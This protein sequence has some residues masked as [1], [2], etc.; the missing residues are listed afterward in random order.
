[1]VKEIIKDPFFLSIKSVDATDED[2]PLAFDLLDTLK[3]NGKKCLGMAA[4]MI[5]VSKKIIAFYDE[6]GFEPTYSIMLNPEIIA[7][8]N[9]YQTKEGCLS[10]SG[11][12]PCKRYQ[13]IKVSYLTEKLVA[14]VKIFTGLTAQIIQHQI[15]HINGVLI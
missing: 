2:L 5:G 13:T 11:K 6:S 14:R 1:M 12:R 7:K 9:L 10:L 15:D 3:A 4:N 8:S